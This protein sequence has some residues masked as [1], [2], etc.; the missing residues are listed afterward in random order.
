[1]VPNGAASVFHPMGRINKPGWVEI[2]KYFAFTRKFLAQAKEEKNLSS[3]PP[4]LM[5]RIAIGRGI[6][7]KLP[8]GST[9]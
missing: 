8:T 4:M 3:S 1:M 9:R 2:E 7:M 5:T 6:P